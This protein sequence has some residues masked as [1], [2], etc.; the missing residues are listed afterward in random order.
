MIEHCSKCLLPSNY[1][2]IKFDDEGVCNYCKGYKPISYLGKEALLK[3]FEKPLSLNKSKKYDCVIGFSG[4][5]DSTFMLWYTVKVLKLRPLAVFAD[6]LFIPKIVLDNIEKT[7]EILGVELRAIK[8][9]NLKKCVTHNLNAWIKRPVPESLMFINV[10][11]RLGYLTLV[12]L[13]A[14]KEGVRLI[15]SGQTYI[16]SRATYKTDLMKIGNK[17]GKKSWLVGYAKQVFL[18]PSLAL[19]FISLKTQYKEFMIGKW[20]KKLVKKHDLHRIHPFYQLYLP[21]IEKEAEDVLFNELEWE[22][23]KGE[24]QTSRVGCE[25]DTL[26]QYLYY[27]TLGYNDNHFDLSGLIRE[28]QLTRKEALDKLK[29]GLNTP[30]EEIKYILTKAGVDADDFLRKLDE[31]YPINTM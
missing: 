28:G 17:G 7:C 25:I 18:N 15:L 4:G 20:R 26:R 6:D 31:K 1:L 23:P 21:W 10:G 13:E 19:N 14:V 22:S 27:R 29:V 24:K 8:H 3:A 9:D 5:K 2:N 12:E 11:E 16:Q 30:I